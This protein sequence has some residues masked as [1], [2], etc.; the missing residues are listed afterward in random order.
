MEGKT[1]KVKSQVETDLFVRVQQA[2]A[3]I[4]TLSQFCNLW[5]GYR[6]QCE[7]LWWED[8]NCTS[9]KCF[10]TEIS[11]TE[12]TEISVKDSGEKAVA[13]LQ[14]NVLQGILSGPK[15]SSRD[16]FFKY[17]HA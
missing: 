16:W 12:M 2:G 8:S 15:N 9:G 11:V 5:Y 1:I 3:N 10:A 6:K 7:G 14:A 4:E 17:M 13:A